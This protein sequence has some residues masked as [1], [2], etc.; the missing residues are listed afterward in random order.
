VCLRPGSRRVTRQSRDR[1][2][3]EAV[4]AA[5]VH[6]R[7]Q[8]DGKRTLMHLISAPS[9]LTHSDGQTGRMTRS[10]ALLHA[11]RRPALLHS[12][13]PERMAE[14]AAYWPSLTSSFCR[15]AGRHARQGGQTCRG[16]RSVTPVTAGLASYVLVLLGAE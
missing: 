9:K 1:S 14:I 8:V 6:G 5:N 7:E 16:H 13:R 12:E 11:P 4:V 3:R 15:A 10:R 2:R